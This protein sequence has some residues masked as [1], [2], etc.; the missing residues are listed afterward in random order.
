MSQNISAEEVLALLFP[1]PAPAGGPTPAV[2]AFVRDPQGGLMLATVVPNRSLLEAAKVAGRFN[3]GTPILDPQTR[4][5]IGYEL[6]P[7]A[8]A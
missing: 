4:E 1:E 2:T 7:L 5:I 8:V 3:S 6:S